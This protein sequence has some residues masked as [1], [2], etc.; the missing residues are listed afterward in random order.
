MDKKCISLWLLFVLFGIF[1][2]YLVNTNKYHIVFC[3]V[4]QGDAILI[5]RG[6][7]QVI[8]D[9]GKDSSFLE[10]MGKYMPFFDRTIELVIATHPDVDHIGGLVEVLNRYK[11]D[12]I[13]SSLV[14]KQE[15]F[16]LL[17]KKGIKKHVNALRYV[18]QNET[19]QID[20]MNMTML[21]PEVIPGNI[22][23]NEV[24]ENVKI[25]EEKAIK[26]DIIYRNTNSHSLVFR[27]KIG[28]FNALFTGDLEKKQEEM[29]V[30]SGVLGKIDVLKVGHHGSSGS[31]SSNFLKILC[32][33]YAVISVGKDNTYGH[34]TKETI[35]ILEENNVKILRTDMLGDIK[36]DIE[37]NGAYVVNQ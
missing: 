29:L 11:V 32:P 13:V 19:I 33:K 4:G 22:D 18:R 8:I 21:W 34:P 7:T 26:E 23:R 10:C 27:L 28:R 24:V 37:R 25:L 17:Y 16:S 1:Y 9:G 35:D 5:W 31:T 6:T 36:V 20:N 12:Q 30:S 14:W 2:Q 3:N 15:A